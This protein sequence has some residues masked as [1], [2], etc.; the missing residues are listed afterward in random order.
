MWLAPKGWKVCSYS[1][2]YVNSKIELLKDQLLR[3]LAIRN[4]IPP[5]GD[6]CLKIAQNGEASWSQASD[7]ILYI[8]FKSLVCY[9]RI[10]HEF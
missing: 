9:S 7:G 10:K 2:N 1:E 5:R 3:N 8:C 4:E 6:Q